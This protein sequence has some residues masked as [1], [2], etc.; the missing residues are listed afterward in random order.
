MQTIEVLEKVYQQRGAKGL[1]LER[2]YRQLFNQELFLQAYGKIYRNFGAMTPGSTKET[3]DS[4]DVTKIQRIIELLR[5]ERYRWTP[6]RRVEILKE[7]GKIRPLGIPTWSD[8]LVQE[9]IRSI[10]ELYYEQRFSDNSHGF[11]PNLSCHSALN[12]IRKKWKGTIWFIEGD[13]KGC[14]DNIDP[15]ILLEIIR[16][17]IHDERLISLLNG[18]LKAGYMK[19]WKFY[20]TILGTPQGG[21][22]SPLLA[23]I[24]LNELDRFVEDTLIPTYTRGTERHNSSEY[25]MMGTAI[26]EAHKRGDMIEFRRLERERRKMPSGEVDD[27]TYRR[28]RYIRYA[29][30]FLLGFVGPKKEADDIRQRLGEF[31]SQN[32]KLTLSEEKTFITNASE[33]K[34]KFL[35]YE[36]QTTRANQLIA[37]TGYSGKRATNGVIL[38][39]MPYAVV[40]KYLKRHSRKGKIVHRFELVEE[41]DYTIISRFQSVLRGLYNFYCMAPNVGTRMGQ[42][43]WILSR[44]LLKTLAR[45]YK[46]KSREILRRYR[47]YDPE[48][49]MILRKV[50]ERPDKEPLI[51]EFGG[52]PLERIPEGMGIKDFNL[53]LAWNLPANKRTEVVTRLL[54]GNCELCEAEGVPIQMHHIRKLAD[55]DQPGRRPKEPWEK[56]MAARRR[57][58]LAVCAECHVL[59]HA[60][61]YDGPRL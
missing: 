14:F 54:A 29:D 10:L 2:V 21:I 55:I 39:K 23:N 5:H 27:P 53:G 49:G 12:R 8:K 47:V 34:A 18:L 52:F 40:Q 24:Y 45:K 30:D 61:R 19:N 15:T 37:K 32:L 38:L 58:T 46:C 31:L 48:K 57:K 13:I 36:I 42:I 60:G 35:G 9:V 17:D 26:S 50:I 11:R 7:N 56:I 44:S 59:I 25:T 6:V 16:R 51:A 43:K 3:V 41:T 33:E 28:L 20:N 22:I 1:P 4:M